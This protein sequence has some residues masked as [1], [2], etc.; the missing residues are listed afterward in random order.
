MRIHLVAFEIRGEREGR[1]CSK[2]IK[3]EKSITGI[4][5]SLTSRF[6]DKEENDNIYVCCA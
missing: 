3:K 2:D 4:G 1:Y 6:R 5:A